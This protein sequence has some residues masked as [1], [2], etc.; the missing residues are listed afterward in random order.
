MPDWLCSMLQKENVGL[1]EFNDM[2]NALLDILQFVKDKSAPV[3][4]AFTPNI[5]LLD[6]SQ[7][8]KEE[9]AP[10]NQTP[11]LALL[12]DLQ[13]VKVETWFPITHIPNPVLVDATISVATTEAFGWILTP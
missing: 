4:S 2:P 7:L 11:D 8:V 12:I 5:E 10:S 1:L 13:F 6:I 3:L 9:V